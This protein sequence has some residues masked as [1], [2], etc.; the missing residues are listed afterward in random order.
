VGI[1]LVLIIAV[2]AVPIVVIFRVRHDQGLQS[3]ISIQWLFGAVQI[4]ASSKPGEKPSKK[5][6]KAKQP[7][8]KKPKPANFQ[9]VK[10]LFWN[11]QFRGRV[12]TFVKDIFESIHIAHF[13]LRIRLG[14]DDPAD[15]GRLWAYFGPLAVYLSNLSNS[16]IHLEPNFLTESVLLDSSGR[17]RI[18]PLQVIFTV[19][20]FLLS[21]VTIRALWLMQ[22]YKK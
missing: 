21:P 4:P 17:V 15:T 11:A 19:L 20:V 6:Y 13:Y 22:K 1:I 3:D 16:A 7:R 8:K 12:F 14:L 10:N 9:S 2:L 5:P 18:I